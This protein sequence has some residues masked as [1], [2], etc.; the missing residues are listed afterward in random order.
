MNIALIL[1]TLL[2]GASTLN[3]QDNNALTMPPTSDLP[4]PPLQN[5]STAPQNQTHGQKAE[6]ERNAQRQQAR[7]FP[8][9]RV[10]RAFSTAKCSEYASHDAISAYRF[11]RGFPDRTSL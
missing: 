4:L 2:I 7:N 8:Y 3:T 5:N 6:Q 1:S 9:F 11:F 10:F